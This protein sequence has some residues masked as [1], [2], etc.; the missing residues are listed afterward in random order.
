[1]PQ[2]TPPTRA[3]ERNKVGFVDVVVG[4]DFLSANETFLVHQCNCVTVGARGIAKAIF[5]KWPQ[6][7]C[8][9]NRVAS[10]K[11][12]GKGKGNINNYFTTTSNGSGGGQ[13]QGGKGKGGQ[14]KVPPST[15]GTIDIAPVGPPH[16][17][18]V[19]V[20]LFS[21]R[22]PGL[23]KSGHGDD[24]KDVR[25]GWFVEC[26]EKLAVHINTLPEA[27]HDVEVAM[28]YLIGCGLAGGNWPRYEDFI[29][30]W[31]VKHGIVVRLYDLDSKSVV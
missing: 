27:T 26:L 23:P 6:A 18:Q 9:R 29:K 5:A 13:S 31:A 14:G 28:P 30:T 17:Q 22:Y 16:K 25:F 21:Q 7:N 24:S 4:G 3:L 11:G 10:G 2:S 20:G 19:V 1:M 8:Y 15:P 12:K